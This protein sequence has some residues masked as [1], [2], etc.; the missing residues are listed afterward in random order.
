MESSPFVV[1]RGFQILEQERSQV[2]RASEIRRYDTQQTPS[3]LARLRFI[4]GRLFHQLAVHLV[5]QAFEFMAM[6]QH[7]YTK[8]LVRLAKASQAL[9]FDI[10]FSYHENGVDAFDFR[11]LRRCGQITHVPHDALKAF[12]S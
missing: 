9:G 12:Y 7:K 5:S 8:C 6:L 10:M 1:S 2:L 3:P 4:V 11:E